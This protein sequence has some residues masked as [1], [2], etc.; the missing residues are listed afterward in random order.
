MRREIMSDYNKPA[1]TIKECEQKCDYP[2]VAKLYRVID[3]DTRIVVIDKDIIA[4]LEKWEKVSTLD[5]LRNSVQLWVQKIQSL[6]LEVIKGHEELYKWT[7]P[8]DPDF[9]GFMA[10]V[11]P[12]VYAQ[13]EGLVI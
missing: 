9:L 5:L 3:A 4:A 1:E 11:L 2:Q 12:L 13:E 6:S 10:G 7:A 8:Y